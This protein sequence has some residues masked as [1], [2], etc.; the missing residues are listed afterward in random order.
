M[1]ERMIAC[2]VRQN[3]ERQLRVPIKFTMNF[4]LAPILSFNDLGIPYDF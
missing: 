2:D 4:P 1:E 3:P